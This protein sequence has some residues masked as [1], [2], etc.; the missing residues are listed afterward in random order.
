MWGTE[1]SVRR[2][3]VNLD[4]LSIF[5][6]AE[7]R[8]APDV[9]YT[10]KISSTWQNFSGGWSRG[11]KLGLHLVR[12]SPSASVVQVSSCKMS[13]RIST[14][15]ARCG[16]RCFHSTEALGWCS[17]ASC[18]LDVKARNPTACTWLHSASPSA[19]QRQSLH[20]Q[21]R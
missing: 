3:C 16:D 1:A 2:L 11:V 15:L 18:R 12:D 5:R 19:L 20:P 4:G 13:A 7:H 8:R 17:R 6:G 10:P 14:R 21:A 9:W